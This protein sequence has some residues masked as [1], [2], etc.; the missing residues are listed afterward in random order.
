[1]ENRADHDIDTTGL[2]GPLPILRARASL[3][4]LRSGQTLRVKT[5]DPKALKD[6]HEFARLSGHRL[7]TIKNPDGS[8]FVLLQK[9]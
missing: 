2:P 7:L 8:F 6:F 1:M 5:S 9:R 4:E 3:K